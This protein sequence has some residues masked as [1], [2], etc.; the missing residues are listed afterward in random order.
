MSLILATLTA[1]WWLYQLLITNKMK[2]LCKVNICN[3]KKYAKLSEKFPI[4]KQQTLERC[5]NL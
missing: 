2:V 5:R 1:T 3:T 4:R